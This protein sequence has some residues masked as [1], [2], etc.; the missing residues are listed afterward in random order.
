[1][2]QQTRIG[3]LDTAKSSEFNMHFFR[4]LAFRLQKRSCKV[5]TVVV[6]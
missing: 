5:S 2:M 6:L 4:L 1:M 3:G